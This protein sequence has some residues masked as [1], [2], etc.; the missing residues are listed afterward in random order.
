MS[1][2]IYVGNLSYDITEKQL[3]EL[4]VQHGE[5]KSVKIITDQYSGKSKGFGFIEMSS[6]TEAQS[7]IQ[8]LDGKAVLDRNIKVNLAKPRNESRKFN[9]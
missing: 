3:E 5:V 7:A 2:N 4:F 1:V 6:N 8:S 9:R